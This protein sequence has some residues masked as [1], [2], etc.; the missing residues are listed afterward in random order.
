VV[1]LSV[2]SILQGVRDIEPKIVG[3]DDDDGVGIGDLCQFEATTL[4][5]SIGRCPIR[6]LAEQ[7]HIIEI[8]CVFPQ[9]YKTNEGILF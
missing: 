9:S 8:L 6:I 5:T 3:C 2:I 4:P 1:C 7:S